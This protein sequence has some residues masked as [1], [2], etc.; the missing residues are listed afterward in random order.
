MISTHYV[1]V[2]ETSET[3][4]FLRFL[5]P[6]LHVGESVGNVGNLYSFLRSYA[7]CCAAVSGGAE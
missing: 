2:S 4:F 6:A 3:P 7:P 1:L 5:R